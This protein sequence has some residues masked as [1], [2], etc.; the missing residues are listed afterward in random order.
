MRFASRET[1]LHSVVLL[2]RPKRNSA[3]PALTVRVAAGPRVGYVRVS[4]RNPRYLEHERDS[5]LPIGENLCMY[6]KEGTYYFDRLLEEL[7]QWRQLCAHLAGIIPAQ[8]HFHRGRPGDAE[9][10]IPVETHATGLGR[11]DWLRLAAR[12][13]CR[14]V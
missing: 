6:Q 4:P 2:E 5:L 9:F 1:G 3:R 11:Y 13:R 8:R 14:R 7:A 10:S 12:S